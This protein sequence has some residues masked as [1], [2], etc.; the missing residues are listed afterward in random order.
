M[1]KLFFELIQVAIGTRTE[2]SRTLSDMEWKSVYEMAKKQALIGICFVGCQRL[3]SMQ[4]PTEMLWLQ[5]LG[6]AAKIQQRNQVVNS[7]CLELVRQYTHD[8]LACCILKGQG[9]WVNYPEEL[10][11]ARNPGDIDVWCWPQDPCGMEIAVSDFDGKGAHYE[12]YHGKEA[13]IEYVKMQHRLRHDTPEGYDADNYE[14]RYHH[15][16]APSVGGVSVEVHTRPIYFSNP[17]RNYHLQRWFEEYQGVSENFNGIPVP[18]VS[19]N[20]VYQLAHINHHLFE[21]GIGLRQLLDYNFVLRASHVEQGELS[22]RTQSM[23]QW[24]EGMGIS[25]MSNTEIMHQLKRF[26]LARIASAVMYVLAHVFEPNDDPSI[27]SGQA[28]NDNWASRWPWMICEPDERLG[29][30]L[31]EEVMLAGNFGKYDTRIKRENKRFLG[32][33][34]S[35]SITR[36]I[37]K[38][39][40]NLLLAKYYPGEA[41]WEPPFRLYHFF[42]RK[43]EMWKI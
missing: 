40:R 28:L 16:D 3:P 33:K 35:S 21:E 15:I 30:H 10:R 9:N 26:G 11:E 25:V 4:R 32:F 43:L 38:T 6:M 18:S 1:I 2:L 19:F 20:V 34:V 17:L 8:G 23:A 22:D 14:I 29:K 41:L 7:A 5:W 36:A 13:V 27:C 24:A 42:W 31:L 37:E 39:K 12:K